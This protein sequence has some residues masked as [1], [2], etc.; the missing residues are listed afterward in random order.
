VF[1]VIKLVTVLTN[2]IFKRQS[3]SPPDPAIINKEEKWDVEKI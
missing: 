3:G 2:S 1:P